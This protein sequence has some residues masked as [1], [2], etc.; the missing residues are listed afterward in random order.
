VSNGVATWQGARDQWKRAAAWEVL[1]Q[2]LVGAQMLAAQS[3]WTEIA[4]ALQTN[5]QNALQG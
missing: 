4:E 1:N 3:G 5:L 2:L